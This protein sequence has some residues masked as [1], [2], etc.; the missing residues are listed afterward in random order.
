[1][2][3]SDAGNQPVLLIRS[4]LVGLRTNKRAMVS[5]DKLPTDF[6]SSHKWPAL[7]LALLPA[8]HCIALHCVL[9][10]TTA[11][12]QHCTSA[13]QQK[14]VSK[15][16]K[17]S[18]S[19]HAWPALSI[20]DCHDPRDTRFFCIIANNAPILPA[21]NLALRLLPVNQQHRSCSVNKANAYWCAV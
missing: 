15:A 3:V 16:V 10:C 12:H 21:N 17:G 18:C 9:R 20:G 7:M 1:M 4:L 5:K 13:L 14:H 8:L 2:Q 6:C 11:L 19:S